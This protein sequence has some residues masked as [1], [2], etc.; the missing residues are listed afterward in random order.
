MKK[1]FAIAVVLFAVV[2]CASTSASAQISVGVGARGFH[3]GVGLGYVPP[4]YGTSIYNESYGYA[5]AYDQY[6]QPYNCQPQYPVQGYYYGGFA[7]GYSCRSYNYGRG[8]G[9]D[10]SYRG[11]ARGGSGQRSH[12]GRR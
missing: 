8:Y 1:L 7:Y 5:C 12:G 4:V 3:V 2:L 10:R 9:L 6:N 11:G